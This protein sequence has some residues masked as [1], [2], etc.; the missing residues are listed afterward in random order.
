MNHVMIDL[1]RRAVCVNVWENQ[2][3]CGIYSSECLE[4][5]DVYSNVKS[6][7]G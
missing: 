5:V 6:S 1:I 2:T 3:K 4:W 7:R